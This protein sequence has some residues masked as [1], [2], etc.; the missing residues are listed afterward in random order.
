[1]RTLIKSGITLA[2]VI[3]MSISPLHGDLPCIVSPFVTDQQQPVIDITVGGLTIG[4]G[5]EQKLAQVVTPRISGVLREVKFPVAC[6]SGDLIVEIQG[7]A[8]STPNGVVLT[9]ETSP[10]SSLISPDPS[11]RSLSFS[12]PISFAAGSS[13]A[14]V[15]RSTGSCSVFQ[16]PLGDPYSGGAGFFDARPN[17]PGWLFLTDRR[18]LPFQTGVET[19]LIGPPTLTLALTGCTSCKAGDTFS[20]TATVRNSECLGVSTKPVRVEIKAGVGLPDGTEFNVWIVPDK[21]FT[22]DLAAGFDLTVELLRVTLPA[23]LPKGGWVYEGALISPELG[24]TLSRDTKS[25][26]IQ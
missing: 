21:H 16:G 13:F 12:K 3:A 2:I 22:V 10:G 14:I 8:E 17:P 25:F 7:V 5:S 11:F 18:D 20:V 23:G 9:S 24:R 26:T 6:S 19:S 15:L 4:G 1:M